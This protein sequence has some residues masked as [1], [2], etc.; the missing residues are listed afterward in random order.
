MTLTITPDWVAV[1]WG[2]TRMR[3]TAIGTGPRS[4]GAGASRA[5]GASTLVPT[6]LGETPPGPGMGALRA[7]EFAP[8]L[9]A[10]IAPW[11]DGRTPDDP[12]DVLAC[13]MVGARQG[14]MEAPYVPV[15]ATL[16]GLLAHAVVPDTGDARVRV[17]IVPGL[18]QDDPPDVMRG[19]ETQLLG[20]LASGALAP[21]P[22]DEASPGAAPAPSRDP[23]PDHL[24]VLPGTH[25]KWTLLRGGP[26]SATGPERGG[27]AMV[28]APR[29]MGFST[30]MT[31]ELF[32]LLSG[33]SILR[34]SMP[35]AGASGARASTEARDE[36]FARGLELARYERGAVLDRL[37]AI[38]AASLLSEPRPE[39]S[40]G[41][42]S[43]LLIGAEIA[44]ALPEGWQGPVHVVGAG[45]LA[46]LYA[47]ALRALGHA[48]VVHD[49]GSLAIAGL[50]AMRGEAMAR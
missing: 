33:E 4:K 29:V 15:P 18:S 31:G 32:A 6:V 25:S 19:E 21:P 14:W 39:A 17:R 9:M 34:H 49:G 44:R 48:A 7:R 22:S 38:R 45:S 47:R 5:A 26:A 10:A 46:G 20:L 28:R 2:T 37:F 3:A 50:A 11:L 30:H 42:L 43:G 8:T 35:S 16:D 1:D 13:G 41:L 27:G 40:R 24:V 23:V 12:L 36:G